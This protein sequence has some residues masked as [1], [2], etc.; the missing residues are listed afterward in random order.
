MGPVD[1]HPSETLL[2]RQRELAA[3]DALLDGIRD[4]GGSLLVRGEPGIGKS[5]LLEKAQERA[6]ARGI[7]VLRTAGAPSERQM[8]FS[9][10]HQLLRP[11]LGRADD[12][13]APQAAALRAAF[14]LSDGAGDHA[15]P[16]CAPQSATPRIA[17]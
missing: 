11:R 3:I 5:A 1:S 10:L 9:G 8:A 13:P 7:A 12:L 17:A 16:G 14:G 4:R 6:T 2:G 15:W